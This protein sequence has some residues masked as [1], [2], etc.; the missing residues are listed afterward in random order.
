MVLR[1][2]GVLQWTALNCISNT[3]P[4]IYVMWKREWASQ[5]EYQGIAQ[6]CRDAIKKAKA[7]LKLKLLCNLK[8]K[9]LLEHIIRK[10]KAKENMSVLWGR[11][12]SD[13]QKDET[14]NAFSALAF[15][16]KVCTYTLWCF[17]PCERHRSETLHEIEKD[18]LSNH[19]SR[20]HIDGMGCCGWQWCCGSYPMSLQGHSLPSWKDCSTQRKFP[21]SGTRQTPHVSFTRARRS[22]WGKTEWSSWPW[23]PGKQWEQSLLEATFKHMEDQEVS[24][25]SQPGFTKCSSYL[26]NLKRTEFPE[27]TIMQMWSYCFVLRVGVAETIS[28][29]QC[30]RVKCL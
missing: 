14:L 24:R 27:W 15:T 26:T 8:D 20:L 12:P 29:K 6:A 22:I 11:G 9:K 4:R 21:M 1:G 17:K 10:S 28:G 16:D 5:V 18:R 25:K 2:K 13:S 23:F 7:Q 19:F 3:W 30:Y